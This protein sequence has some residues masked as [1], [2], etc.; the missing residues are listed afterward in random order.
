MK[1]VIAIYCES[2]DV[3]LAVISKNT[4]TGKPAVLKTASI[5]HSKSSANLDKPG[6]FRVEEESLDL[7][8]VDESLSTKGE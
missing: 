5:S 8:G 1:P 7:E 3:K 4:A 2:N 6:G